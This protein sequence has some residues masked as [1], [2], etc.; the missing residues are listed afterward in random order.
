MIHIRDGSSTICILVEHADQH[1]PQRVVKSISHESFIILYTI[2]KPTL[3][4][5]FTHTSISRFMHI[6]GENKNLLFFLALEV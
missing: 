1:P 5:K 4:L 6:Y 3:L 2:P